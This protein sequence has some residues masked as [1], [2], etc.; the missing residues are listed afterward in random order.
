MKSFLQTVLASMFLITA[1]KNP[2]K[3]DK[4]EA[5]QPQKVEETA[6]KGSVY[7]A[8]LQKVMFSG[9][10]QLLFVVNMGHFY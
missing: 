4:A 8:D 10:L 9:P 3:A 1:C 2:P 5:A 6:I 7:N